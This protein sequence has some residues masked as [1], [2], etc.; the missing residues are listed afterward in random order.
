MFP[1]MT[2]EDAERCVATAREIIAAK[3]RA[4]VVLMTGANI[5]ANQK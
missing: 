1:G 3:N 5:H 2:D 4:A